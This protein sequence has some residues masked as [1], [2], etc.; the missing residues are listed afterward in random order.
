MKGVV[1]AVTP[2]GRRLAL[3]VAAACGYTVCL[4]NELCE[5][6]DQARPFASLR[7][8]VAAAFAENEAL[9][10]IMACGIAVRLLA[11]LVEDKQ[12]DP[13]VVV[14]DEGGRFAISLLSGHWGGAN[15][16]AQ[17]L[18]ETVGAVPVITTAT[19]VQGLCAVDVLAREIG[20]RPQPF[21]R[22][23]DFNAAMLRGDQVGV[24][25][26]MPELLTA[27][28][29]GLTLFE[30]S[31]LQADEGKR[32]PYRALLT[33]AARVDGAR[34]DDL[35]LRPPNLHVGVGCR[36]G[37]PAGDIL[38]AISAVLE[39][40]NLAPASLAG[41]ASIDRKQ[42]EAGLLEAA[43]ELNVPVRFFGTDE[44]E[45]VATPCQE[46]AFVKQTMGVGAVCEPTA[47]LAARGGRLIVRKQKMKGITIAVAE[48]EYPWWGWGPAE[49]G[50]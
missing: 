26:V 15:Q 48:A 6:G 40:H 2:G 46:S 42:D 33:N 34:D 17:R 11:P 18:A 14:M 44:I 25:T 50:H 37:M 9:V 8:A 23:K 5:A 36:R 3:H 38:R 32:V 29:A 27:Q 47:I 19:D 39:T 31:R 12:R 28:Y 7:E 10:L 43:D 49:K 22:V 45:T 35:Y 1:F 30:F 20:V 13:A 16:L 21:S 4:P 41:L 24:F